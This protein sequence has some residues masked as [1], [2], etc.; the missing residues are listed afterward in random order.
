MIAALPL[1][2][3]GLRQAWVAW[4]PVA[5]GFVLLYGPAWATLSRTL[6]T[7]DEYSN[8]PVVGAIALWLLW[9]LRER[10]QAAPG[11]PHDALG[12]A[13]LAVGLVLALAGRTVAAPE[14]EMASQIPVL[15]GVLLL[16]RGPAALRIA[17][18]PVAFLVFMI[19]VPGSI[20]GPM[21]AGLKEWISVLAEGLLYAA[22]LPVAR[23]GVAID[24]G[25]YRLFVADAC[26][27]LHSMLS[28]SALGVLYV[29]LSRRPSVLHN[30][31]LLASILPIAFLANLLRVLLLLL[32]TYHFGDATARWL[33]DAA[34]LGVFVA[35]L[36]LLYALDRVL[37]WRLAR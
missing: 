13:A 11:A 7:S 15:A 12:G 5:A 19:P 25:Q 23:D 14:L 4:W 24:I 10:L 28:L 18:F 21:T 3:A 26:A 9:R 32:T 16:A 22:G 37:A 34:G 8:G 2:R 29:H 1:E 35:E 30:A 17:W 20:L 27:G 31:I 36:T 6:W 33:H